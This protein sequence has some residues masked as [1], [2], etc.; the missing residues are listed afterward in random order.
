VEIK[1][2]LLLR[3]HLGNLIQLSYSADNKARPGIRMRVIKTP[4]GL[5]STCSL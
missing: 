1:R 2:R 5:L 3:K 4:T